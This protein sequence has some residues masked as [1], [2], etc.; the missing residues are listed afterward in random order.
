MILDHININHEKGRHDWVKSFYGES[1]LGCAWDPRKAKNLET[2]RKT[3]WAN[4]GAHQFHLSEGSPEAQVLNGLVTVVHP[5]LEVLRGRYEAIRCDPE[6]CLKNSLFGVTE[7]ADGS[8]MV[9]DPWGSVFRIVEGKPLSKDRDDRGSQP[10]DPS[11]GW[12]IRD[13]TVHVPI[14][15]NL[16]GIGRFYRDILGGELVVNDDDDNSNMVKIRMGPL[17]TLTFVPKE[18]TEVNAHVDLREI[19]DETEPD[20]LQQRG[21]STTLGNY[22]VHISLYVADLPSC[23][24]RAYDLGLTYVNTR[25][26]RRAY[27]LEQAVDDCMFRC[28]DIVD[29][30]KVEDGPILRLEHEVRSVLKRDGSKYKSCPFEQIPEGCVTLS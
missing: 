24:Q 29:P 20:E 21:T 8:L 26:S 6:S 15:A 12:A 28:L 25:F 4:V 19:Q 17:Q 23:Y 7:E 13:L 30:E 14:D 16:D 27:T 2:G 22:G 11:E 18:S 1:F 10:G 3:L 9:T 5:S